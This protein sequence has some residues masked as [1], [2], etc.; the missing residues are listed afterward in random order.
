[1]NP[2]DPGFTAFVFPGVKTAT[3]RKH[4]PPCHSLFWSSRLHSSL[5]PASAVCR[6][7]M[8][9]P[10][11]SL[12]SHQPIL[13]SQSS[14]AVPAP[15][16]SSASPALWRDASRTGS[17]V[18]NSSCKERSSPASDREDARVRPTMRSRRE[19]PTAWTGQ[20]LRPSAL[21]PEPSR[22]PA[23]PA[24]AFS[25][26]LCEARQVVG[27]YIGKSCPHIELRQHRDA[28]EPH[29]VDQGIHGWNI[30]RH[31]H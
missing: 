17:G 11:C 30:E 31:R 27:Q 25:G 18:E 22:L 6:A 14:S 15:S 3:P 20:A 13:S 16:G 8:R 23:G 19:V 5:Y 2:R 26:L 4:T 29:A 1:M 24:F 7:G 10:T 12:P 28:A 21:V 9:I